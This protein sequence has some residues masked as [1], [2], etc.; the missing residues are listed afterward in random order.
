MLRI[1]LLLF[2][3]LLRRRRRHL[4]LWRRHLLLGRWLRIGRLPRRLTSSA[5]LPCPRLL[6][7]RLPAE[8]A[9]GG[10]QAG[11]HTG[12]ESAGRSRD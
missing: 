6:H 11:Q 1:L 10:G 12:G 5:L 8:W 2:L 9:D 4:L 3:L 7:L